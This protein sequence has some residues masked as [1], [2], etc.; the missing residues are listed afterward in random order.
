MDLLQ[1]SEMIATLMNACLPSEE[2]VP[3]LIEE[4]ILETIKYYAYQNE[5]DIDQ[6]DVEPLKAYPDIEILLSEV[7]KVMNAKTYSD[8]NFDNLSEILKTRFKSLK[9][10]TRGK[11]LNCFKSLNYSELFSSNAIINISR[12]SGSKDKSLIMSILM[13]SLY[14]YCISCYTHNSEYRKLAMQNKLLHFTVV[15]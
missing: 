1:H 13:Q 8:T 2:V 10:G 5:C 12:L 7:S 15:E 11:I 4:T 3:I 9:R 6:G 14:E